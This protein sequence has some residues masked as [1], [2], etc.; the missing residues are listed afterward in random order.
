VSI[1]PL[2]E[3]RYLALAGYTRQPW[4][5]QLVQEFAWFA[6]PSERVLGLLTWDRQDYDF[7]WV[8]LARDERLRF[9]A[10]GMDASLPSA[11][12]AQ[13]ALAAAME[14][15]ELEPDDAFHQ[16]DAD[17][18]AI[19]F[20]EP[21]APREHWH[22]SFRLL[23]EDARYSPARELIGAMMRYHED[24]DGNFVQ[25]FQT[26][27]FDARVWELYLFAVFTELGFARN[28]DLQVPDFILDGMTGSLAVE[29]TSANPAE[30]QP[31]APP[32]T[33]EELTPYLE[34]YVPIKL[35]RALR[36]K[37][38]RRPP[39]WEVPGM[40]GRP[41][42]LA[43]QDFHNPGVMRMI[44]PAA[45]ELAFGVRHRL[46]DGQRVIERIAEHRFGDAVQPSGL[47]F[48]PSAE[49]LSAV[50]VNPQ[51]T[52]VKFNR[53]GLIAGFGDRR[54]RMRR[55]GVRRYD[56]NIADP[57]PRPFVEDVHAPGY[58]ETWIEGAV[59]LHNPNA[60]LPLDPSSIVGATHEFLEPDGS[61]MSLLPDHPPYWS[62][63]IVWLDDDDP[64]APE[65]VE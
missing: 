58:T 65:P 14:R 30:D 11:A 8:A 52:L 4:I 28:T 37:L 56:S 25:Q 7:G 5:L 59:V 63:T 18:P 19:D 60:N 9:R 26:V 20:F 29:A 54:V 50:L 45:T 49:N 3:R 22:P 12:A 36:S 62:Q 33:P 23:L 6:T 10:V 27:A 42:V 64:T 40:E 61:I 35:S 1:E 38:R 16:G 48:Q 31:V 32:R 34:N 15:L 2:D 57:R 24:V 21:R 13:A 55:T 43:V 47:F 17:G 39:Y 53:L 51:G 44:I 41:F 46:V